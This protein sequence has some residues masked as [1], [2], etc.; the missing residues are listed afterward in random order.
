MTSTLQQ[1]EIELRAH[2]V[3]LRE[4][5]QTKR[6]AKIAAE[7]ALERASEMLQAAECSLQFLAQFR[8]QL[9]K[10]QV[11]VLVTPSETGNI[12]RTCPDSS[13]QE[14]VQ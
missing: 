9:V 13:S 5:K 11:T 10:F 12:D 6:S 1:A 4:D 8:E 7:E 3:R 2:I 14:G